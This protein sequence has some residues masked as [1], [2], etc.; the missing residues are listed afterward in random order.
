MDAL[1]AAAVCRQ[2]GLS[3]DAASVR[4]TYS[5]TSN[6]QVVWIR[7]ATCTGLEQSLDECQLN[8]TAAGQCTNGYAVVECLPPSGGPGQR[9]G[10]A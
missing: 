2:L 3:G 10:L 8:T 1:G 9:A 6:G 5:S 4:A 7:N